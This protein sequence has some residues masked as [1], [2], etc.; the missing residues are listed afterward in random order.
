[1]PNT[2]NS[3]PDSSLIQRLYEVGIITLVS[4]NR[5]PKR[6]FAAGGL[7]FNSNSSCSDSR[8][9]SVHPYERN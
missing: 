1:M 6:L 3:S 5:S 8:F 9:T 2:L 4:G 7:K